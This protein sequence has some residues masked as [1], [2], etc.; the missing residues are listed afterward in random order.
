MIVSRD[1]RQSLPVLKHV[2][3]TKVIGNY[4]KK[5]YV[6]INFQHLCLKD[7]LRVCNNKKI[8][9]MAFENQQEQAF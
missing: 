1:F 9:I 8:Q 6:W 3:R 2:N 7:D 5:F 4:V